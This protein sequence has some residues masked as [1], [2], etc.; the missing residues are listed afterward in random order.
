LVQSAQQQLLRR[1]DDTLTDCSNTVMAQ[2]MGSVHGAEAY[3]GAD[4]KRAAAVE[5]HSL[6]H[7]DECNH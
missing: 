5:L 6:A 7:A 3:A 2:L 4:D 1:V